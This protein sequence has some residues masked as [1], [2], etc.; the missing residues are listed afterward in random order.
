M[1][2]LDPEEVAG[3]DALSGVFL[4]PGIC[5][6]DSDDFAGVLDDHLFGRDRLQ[7]EEAPV[8]NVTPFK[9]EQ[10]ERSGSKRKISKYIYGCISRQN[11]T[12]YKACD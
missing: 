11:S 5:Y 6:G 3:T 12:T 1:V 10:R 8:V 7:R 9:H 2:S 4:F